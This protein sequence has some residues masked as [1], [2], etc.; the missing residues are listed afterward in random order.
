MLPNISEILENN[1][2]VNALISGRVYRHGDAPQNVTKPYVTWFVVSGD[3][4]NNLSS[5]P[6]TDKISLQV[7]NWASTDAGILVLAKAVRDALEPYAHMVGMPINER[8]DKTKL[9]RI[10]LEFDWFLSR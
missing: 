5:V 8:D 7:D 6:D 10:A 9:Y 4:E 3:P 1:V 2:A